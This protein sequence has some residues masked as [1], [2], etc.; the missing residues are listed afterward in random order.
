MHAQF[1]PSKVALFA[2]DL[3][4]PSKQTI[5]ARRFANLSAHFAVS[6]EFGAHL[7]ARKGAN[8]QLSASL[9]GKQ[10]SAES[11]ANSPMIAV[12]ALLRKARQISR[13]L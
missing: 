11:K 9:I 4:P 2:V 6:H 7:K 12:S 5:E 10:A 8:S 13:V 1:A 3:Q